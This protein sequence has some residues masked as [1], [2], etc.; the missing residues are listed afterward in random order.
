VFPFCTYS[1]PGKTSPDRQVL[2]AD[3]NLPGN[4]RLSVRRSLDEV[5]Q[6]AEGLYLGKGYFHA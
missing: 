6:V 3:Y 2:R 1:A 4:P 5:L